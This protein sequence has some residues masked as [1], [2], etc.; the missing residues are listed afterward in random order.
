M[1]LRQLQCGVRGF[2]EPISL[3]ISTPRGPLSLTDVAVLRLVL[4]RAIQEGSAWELG[5][6]VW[7]GMA[8]KSL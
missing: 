4:L 8:W 3:P 2:C 1:K 7:H 5:Q 6:S